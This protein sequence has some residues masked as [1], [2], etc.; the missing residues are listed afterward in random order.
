MSRSSFAWN[1]SGFH[2]SGQTSPFSVTPHFVTK[3]ERPGSD[4]EHPAARTAISRSRTFKACGGGA[5]SSS[6]LFLLHL[7]RQLLPLGSAVEL[8]D[9]AL[10]NAAAARQR[11]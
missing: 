4:L 1:S 3:S 5:R 6:A 10:G 8:L 2:P 9:L 11:V 7:R